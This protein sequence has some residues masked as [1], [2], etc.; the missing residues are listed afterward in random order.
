MA[1]NR[2]KIG[3]LLIEDGTISAKTL[4]RALER[5]RKEHKKIGLILEEMGVATGEEIADVL[6]R[7]FG[8]RRVVN[9]AGYTFAKELLD[10]VTVD[11]A[12]RHL[13]FPLRRDENKLYL[14]MADPTD[15]KIVS[16]LAQNNN[17]VIIPHIATRADIL[18]A[19]SKH[20]LGR[21]TFGE[22]RKTV[23]IVDDSPLVVS[24]IEQVL[25]REGYRV[26]S[27]KDGIDAFKRAIADIP[28]V[29]VTDKE[30]PGL[31]GY[32]LIDALKSLPE[33]C[34]IPVILHTASPDSAEEADA[35]RKGF[36]DFMAKPVKEVTLITR[37]KRAVDTFER[38][39]KRDM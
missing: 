12:M 28:S 20:Y 11:T 27:A 38:I 29:I 26:E 19:I 17:L 24:E 1:E 8:C 10:L 18:A 22:K 14:A 23:L 36:F 32:R 34:N 9:F 3:E 35:Y 15:T 13:L 16:N 21:E 31:S 7:Q 2:K 30:M 4:E 5:S 25:I 33:T 39:G 6:A 37:V